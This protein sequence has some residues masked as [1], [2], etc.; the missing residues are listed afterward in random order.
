MGKNRVRILVHILGCIGFLL[1]PV[2]FAPDLTGTR[3]LLSVP[4][5]KRDFLSYLLLIAFFYF[6]FFIL[7]PKLYLNKKHLYFFLAV[8]A[9]FIFILFVPRLIFPVQPFHPPGADIPYHPRTSR[10]RLYDY[11]NRLLQFLIVLVFSLLLKIS[12]RWKKVEKEKMSA[13]LS[14]L[15]AQINPHFLFNTLN[16]IYSLAIQRSDETPA[17]VIK[18]SEMMRYVTTEAHSDLVSLEKELNYISN[19]IELQKIRLGN[20]VKINY[21][22]EGAVQNKQITPLVLIPFVENAFKYGVN[23]EEDCYITI[24]I[25]ITENVLIFNATN[26]KVQIDF[27]KEPQSGHGIKNAAQRLDLSYAGKHKLEIKDE[28]NEYSV[29][30][31][32]TLE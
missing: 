15:K 28:Q 8:A 13:E 11:G 31:L 29:S 6:S 7:I 12:D 23:P 22:N 27:S 20:T 16:S 3:S 26:K 18:L 9:C 2:L 32:I 10:H 17:A 4:P 30:L 14:Y 5:F 24:K 21:T 19:Y 1:I 25:V